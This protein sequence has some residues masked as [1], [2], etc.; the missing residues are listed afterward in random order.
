MLRRLVDHPLTEKVVIALIMVN[1][2]TLGLETSPSVMEAY[3][4]LLVAV[5]RLLLTIFVAELAA[6]MVVR[7]P[8]FFADPWNVFDFLVVA[9]AL[10]PATGSLSVLRALRILRVL[11][12]ITVVPS[13]RAVVSAL[14]GALPGM[15][16][17]MLLLI[18]IFYVFA[19][20]G[21]KLFG[22][23]H[24]ET[25]GSIG[26]SMLSLFQVMTLDAWSDGLMRP[27]LEKYPHAWLFFIPFVLVSAFIVLN[28]FIGVVVSA[29]ETERDAERVRKQE[30]ATTL[31]AA[32]GNAAADLARVSE[33]LDSLRARVEAVEARRQDPPSAR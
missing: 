24:E 27:M 26:A 20:M 13:L 16:S 11:R 12:L 18:L 31:S 23:T 15:G 6:R 33:S 3:G 9:I 25:F 14:V 10:L 2:V 30:N 4:G 28:L 7:G 8:R 22:E 5:D 17:I 29:L 1:A 19:V 32:I 21:T